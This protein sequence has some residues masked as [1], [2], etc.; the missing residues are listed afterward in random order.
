MKLHYFLTQKSTEGNPGPTNTDSLVMSDYILK[1]LK[2]CVASPNGTTQIPKHPN[3]KAA[4]GDYTV[5]FM[6]RDYLENLIKK[7]KLE[8]SKKKDTKEELAKLKVPSHC[9]AGSFY[10]PKILEDLYEVVGL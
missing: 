5:Y 4:D 7:S 1:A 10:S 3:Q 2:Y 8:R 6:E 9:S